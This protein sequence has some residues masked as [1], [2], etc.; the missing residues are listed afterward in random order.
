MDPRERFANDEEAIRTAM[1][2]MRASLWTA[3]PGII[4][5]FDPGAVTCVVQ[6]ALKGVVQNPDGTSSAIN[7]PLLLDVPVMYP[8]GG[9]CTLTFP[10]IEG[11]ECLVV[12]SS[13]CIDGW[14]QSGGIQLPMEI[15]FHDLSDGFAFVG[16]QSQVKKISN[17]STNTVQLRSDDGEAFIQLNPTNYRIDVSTAGSVTAFAGQN[18]TVEAQGDI[19]ATAQGSATI[20]ASGDVTVNAGGS[21]SVQ[22]GGGIDGSATGPISLTSAVSVSLTAPLVSLNGVISLNGPITQI[23]GSGGLRTA[24]L[25]GPLNVTHNIN[26]ADTVNAAAVA[27][28]GDVTAGAISLATHHHGNVQNGGG[29]TGGP[30]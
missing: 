3:L 10:I 30:T 22:A 23:A 4:Q 12:F 11:D 1:Q 9:G 18:I 8:R 5:S 6:P 15:R 29:I 13:R 27:A 20:A 2:G 21:V 19:S 24:T 14:W 7:L 16:P 25:I 17:I 28:T 26:T